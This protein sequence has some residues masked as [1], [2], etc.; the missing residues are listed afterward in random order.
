MNKLN[1]LDTT[2]ELAFDLTNFL[3]LVSK[4]LVKNLT[5]MHVR[6]LRTISSLPDATSIAVAT[7]LKRDKAQI[8]R[9]VNELLLR[10]LVQRLPNPSDG[11]SQLLSLTAKGQTLF[12][13][14]EEVDVTIHKTVLAGVSQEEAE[15]FVV[16]AKKMSRNLDD[17]KSVTKTPM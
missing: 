4:D 12:S 17:A 2:F 7:A 14:L 16:T 15:A 6:V 1:I 8:T 5:P 9:L 11:R 10:E 13:E 3:C